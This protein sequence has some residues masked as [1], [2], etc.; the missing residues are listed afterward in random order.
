MA[1]SGVA[2]LLWL[3]LEG[4]AVCKFSSQ[5][6]GWASKQW[7]RVK[8]ENSNLCPTDVLCGVIYLMLCGTSPEH[9]RPSEGARVMWSSEECLCQL[10]C[11]EFLMGLLLRADRK[12]PY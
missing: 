2:S 4:K 1:A 5:Q 8:A 11:A 3:V 10:P 7:R 12:S 9:L 6:C